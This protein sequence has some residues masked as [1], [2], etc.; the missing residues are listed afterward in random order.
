QHAIDLDA[1]S[2]V[3]QSVRS[4]QTQIVND[5]RRGSLFLPNPLL[6]ETRSEMAIPLVSGSEVLGVLDVQSNRVGRFDDEDAQVFETLAFQ[7]TSAILNARLFEE[8][9]LRLREVVASNQIVEFGRS[10]EQLESV[11]ENSLRVVQEVMDPDNLVFSFY[12][13]EADTWRGF[14]GVG[15]S[16]SNTIAQSFVDPGSNYPHGMEAIETREVVGVSDVTEYPD[17]PVEYIEILGLRSVMVAPIIVNDVAIGVFFL[18]YASHARRFTVDDRRFVRNIALQ[19]SLTME[20]RDAESAVRRQSALVEASQDFISIASLDGLVQYV[21][22]AGLRLAGYESLEDIVGSPISIFQSLDMEMLEKVAIPIMMQ[23]GFWRGETR[24]VRSDGSTIPVD[25]TI[26][27]ITDEA[28][29]AIAMATIQTDI[30]ARKQEAAERAL[31]LEISNRLNSAQSFADIGAAVMPYLESNDVA[32]LAVMALET[33]EVGMPEQVRILHNW[34]R[35]PDTHQPPV[36]A[37]MS[38]SDFPT[39]EVWL[40]NPTTPTIF[41]DIENSPNVDDNL[42]ALYREIGVNTTA[43]V[44]LFTQNRWVGLM[45]FSWQDRQHV[46]ERNQRILTSIQRQ[47]ASVLDAILQAEETRIA[48]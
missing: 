19:L 44:P 31:L 35:L 21:N 15:E 28:G 18:N 13:H 5:V 6:S 24:L 26:F 14:V 45:I 11:I 20:R 38:L 4:Q 37:V 9:Q 16:M 3:A 43:E 47:A 29:E 2:I 32:T 12:D 1:R 42:R 10:A 48:R 41:E 8:T 34:S 30:S 17:F 33:D 25:Q 46:D 36:G 7:L 39:A 23:T 22:P 27:P 40:A